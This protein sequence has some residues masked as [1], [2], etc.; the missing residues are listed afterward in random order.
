MA[1]SELVSAVRLALPVLPRLVGPAVAADVE[2]RLRDII[3]QYEAGHD[4][5]LELLDAVA[6]N[7]ELGR[8]VRELTTPRRAVTRGGTV[9]GTRGAAEL[10][11]DG[12][13]PPTARFVNTLVAEPGRDAPVSHG[14]EPGAQY[15]VLVHIGRY[16]ENSLLAA[17]DAVWPEEDLPP[18]GLWLR[19]VLTT[20]EDESPV[21]RTVFLAEHGESFSCGCP[22]SEA[23][24][25]ACEARAWTRLP[26]RTPRRSGVLHA[27]LVI[28]YEV[29]AV[30]AQGLTLPLG[31]DAPAPQARLMSRLTRNF[32]DLGKLTGRSA[33]LVSMP[34]TSRVL[35]NGVG[36]ADNPFALPPSA[37]DTAV[38][39]SRQVLYDSHF[40]IRADAE[41][42][43]F[44]GSFGKD[45]TGFEADLRRLARTGAE[46][47][48]R[49]FSTPGTGTAVVFSLPEL[50]RHEALMRSRPPVLHVADDQYDERS[51]LWATVYDLPMGSDVSRYEPCPAVSEFGPGGSAGDPPAFCPYGEAH[52]GQPNILCP[53]GFWGL[54]CVLEQPF[55]MARHPG[56]VIS[57]QRAPVTCLV[58]AG[59]GLDP[60][61]LNTHLTRLRDQLGRTAVL[62]PALPSERELA[63]ALAPEN[64]DVV[65]LLLSLRL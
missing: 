6:S 19:A 14:L 53:W 51:I 11:S 60:G 13:S 43:V 31:V 45:E 52:R 17:E 55:G 37:A 64:M 15:E 48:S 57:Y 26:F 33:S 7:A 56:D 12:A 40:D 65:L 27:E 24:T 46:L 34:G 28:Y 63:A 39:N 42:S 58:A 2:Q 50:L 20:D 25:A 3:A 44:D 16:L 29:V 41:Y 30:H 62:E 22:V 9:G 35:V 21:V 36:F 1:E 47:Y 4:V 18:G 59:D 10:R 61:L 49:L 54:S 38:L 23:H 5:E 8:L 32:A